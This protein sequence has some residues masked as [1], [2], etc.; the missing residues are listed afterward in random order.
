MCVPTTVQV[1]SR[2]EGR[3]TWPHAHSVLFCHVLQAE[4]P[5]ASPCLLLPWLVREQKPENMYKIQSQ[6]KKKQ[7]ESNLED[8][9]K[10]Q[11]GRGAG[12]PHWKRNPSEFPYPSSQ[13]SKRIPKI[14][15]NATLLLLYRW[16]PLQDKRDKGVQARPA[17]P[18]P[19]VIPSTSLHTA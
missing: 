14:T 13:Y 18:L 2:A 11:H 17:S 4:P 3:D 6:D 16:Q 19:A 9:Q 8:E 12:L 1:T 15:Q 10:T 5:L 7:K